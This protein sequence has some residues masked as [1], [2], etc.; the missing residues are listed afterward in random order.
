MGVID[1]I[2]NLAGLLLW[3]NWRAARLDPL[4]K[5]TPATLIGTLRR[6]E[7]R[8]A[9]RWQ[10]AAALG[11][12]LLLRALFYWQIGSAL[13]PV[14]AGKL[15]LGAIVLSIPCH[16]TWSGLGRMIVFSFCSFALALAVFYTWLILLSILA[17]PDP[18]QALVRMQLGRVQR[19]PLT[20][21]WL[22]P[23]VLG[24]AAWWL[25]S[26]VLAGLQIIPLP[27]SAARRLAGA[28]IIGSESYLTWKLLIAALLVLHLLNR[29]IYFG[30]QPFWAYVN[31]TSQTL[32]R[33]VRAILRALWRGLKPLL[34]RSLSLRLESDHYSP[35][36][37]NLL[38]SLL[39]VIGIAL[40]FLLAEGCGSLLTKLYRDLAG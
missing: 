9:G 31:Q 40:V 4:A 39:N 23:V 22:L 34:P 5:R 21:K 38:S 28:F 10:V 20:V 3:L 25:A 8:G 26:W 12:L 15:D 36:I 30:K 13:K 2:L 29:Y 16:E 6:A 32:L 11:A 17:G 35:P 18:V 24:A 37:R 1:F 19:W 14:W 27:S 7:A 33:P